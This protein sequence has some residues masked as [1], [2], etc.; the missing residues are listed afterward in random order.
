M[1][2][3]A[4]LGPVY[5]PDDPHHVAY[6][7]DA[8]VEINQTGKII[9]VLTPNDADYQGHLRQAQADGRLTKLTPGQ[10]LVPGF[11]DLHVHAPQ[12]PQAGHALDKP[13]NEWLNDYTF[14]LEAKYEDLEFVQTVYHDLVHTL[15]ANGTTTVLFFGTIHT[16]AN[17]VL[18][19][20]CMDQG[21]RSAIGRVAMD[22]PDQTPAYY[23]DRSSEE[24]IA[25][26]ER[27]IQALELLGQ[28]EPL[29]PLP[30]ITPR[31]VPSCTDETLAGL[32]RLAQKYDL[33]IQSHVSESNW[34]HQYAIDRFGIHDAEVLDRFGLLTDKTVLAHGTQ[35]TEADAK[36]LHERG[37]ALAHCPISNAYFGNGVLPVKQLLAAGN[38]V[39]LGTDI[40]GGYSP[41]LYDN[42]RHAVALSQVRTDGVTNADHGAPDSRIS[43]PTAFYLATKGGAE[44][45]NLPVGA[46]EAGRQADLQILTDPHP[47]P[48]ESP[49]ERFERL[50]Y[51]ANRSTVAAVMVNGNWVYQVR[52]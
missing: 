13:L 32:G 14:P 17:L 33:P 34:E 23:R 35:L 8:L 46:I 19:R 42:I 51:Q 40:S 30:V 36:L 24:A 27:F 20:E 29:A 37:T 49:L 11:V 15:L 2:K 39:G 3:T 16:E 28:D 22:N 7:Q 10:V 38:E 18:A 6:L 21:L 41:S 50:M 1:L 43:M 9:A 4:I 25:E 12:W 31:F 48:S 5:T 45:L 47:W 44:A 52:D 26:T